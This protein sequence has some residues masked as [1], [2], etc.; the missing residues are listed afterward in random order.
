[1][2]DISE[3]IHHSFAFPI[4]NTVVGRTNFIVDKCRGKNVLHLGCVDEGFTKKR[5]EDGTLLHS[6]LENAASDL[7]GVDISEDGVEMLKEQGFENLIVGDIEKVEEIKGLGDKKFD[8]IL[9]SEVLEHL[10]NPG[11]FLQGIK[12]IFT[13]DT[14]MIVT[15]PNGL[16]F[17]EFS[18]NLKG[19][20]HVHPDHNFWFSYKTIVTLMEKNGYII[21][22]MIG[23]N[24]VDHSI[25]LISMLKRLLLT[26]FTYIHSNYI[27]NSKKNISS[28]K[29]TNCTRRKKIYKNGMDILV[30]KYF[31][32]R[33]PFF[34]SKGIII[35][36]KLDNC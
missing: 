29:I 31:S 1:M 28:A 4:V 17:F 34:I 35:I 6:K 30:S 10:N 8:I 25:S 18:Q 13:D 20:E 27:L 5:I 36:A 33:N 19:Y 21:D 22:D 7:W 9:V 15:V 24:F 3:S 14:L 2:K 32:R 26:P 11:L 12:N 23:Y 16:N